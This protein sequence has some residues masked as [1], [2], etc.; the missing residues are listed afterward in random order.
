MHEVGA[1]LYGLDLHFAAGFGEGNE[2]LICLV[3]AYQHLR[4]KFF[5]AVF[6]NKD[7]IAANANQSSL[8]RHEPD[9]L[10][11]QLAAQTE[12]RRSA[13]DSIRRK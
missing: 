4:N 10:L 2:S 6:I 1:P 12:H 3:V 8:P 11:S 13:G 9:L 7:W 5:L